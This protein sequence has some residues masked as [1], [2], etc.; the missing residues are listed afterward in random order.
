MTHVKQESNK[1]LLQGIN[2][3]KTR[4]WQENLLKIG[5]EHIKSNGKFYLYLYPLGT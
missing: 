1:N 2:K 4:L 5:V 3:N